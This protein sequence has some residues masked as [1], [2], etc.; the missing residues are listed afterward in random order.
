MTDFETFPFKLRSCV[1]E[2]TLACCFKCLYCG[3]CGGKARENELTAEEC[4]D[5]ARQLKELGCRRVSMI[6]GEVFMRPD[7]ES[8][9]RSLTSR[10]IKT[11]IITNG[12]RM[13][14][15]VISS[16]KRLDIESVAVSVDGPERVHDAFRQEG[17][18]KRA[19][20]AIDALTNA[21]IPVSVISALRA[22]NAP[23]L[24]EFYET[25]KGCPIFAW[26]I[27][28]CSPMGNAGK[29]SVD[30]RFSAKDVIRFVDSVADEAPFYVGIADNIGYFTREEGRVRGARGAVFG[31][32]GAGL[33]AIGIDSVGNV[34]GCESMYDEAFIEGNL[35]ERSLKDIWT[36][37][38]S[39]RYNRGFDESML[40][41]TCR[42]CPFGG[43]CAGGCRS[44][45]YFTTGRLYESPL[46]A[47]H[48]N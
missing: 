11:C 3:S 7:W 19:F 25:L 37:P 17:S 33:D 14:D 48:E 40:T 46:C 29:N 23:H 44:Y 41:G 31:G 43:V 15:G 20:A 22:D 35:R 16:L 38:A 5:V 4:D 47:R 32:C 30:V 34:R 27:Q 21:G 10:G 36:D 6:G 12:F 26:Q 8:I 45:N 13:S 39:F 24:K 18:Y 2:I 28:A 42:G 9:V 1:W